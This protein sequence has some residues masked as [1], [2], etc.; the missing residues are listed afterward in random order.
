MIYNFYRKINK[1]LN[2][3]C[4]FYRYFNEKYTYKDLKN[5]YLKF[6]NITS[7]IKNS[8]KKSGD[9]INV[10]ITKANQNSLEAVQS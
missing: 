4:E 2:S 8:N 3:D 5:L 7:Y 6:L 1:N 9:L 10:L